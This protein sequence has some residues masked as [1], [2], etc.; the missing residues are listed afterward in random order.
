MENGQPVRVQVATDPI[1]Q[2]GW[3]AVRSTVAV[4]TGSKVEP[5]DTL[6]LTNTIF[7]RNFSVPRTAPR[8]FPERNF[9]V[10]CSVGCAITSRHLSG[11]A[12]PGL[13]VSACRP[14]AGL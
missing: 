8:D 3:E 2:Q 5:R 6:A 1:G 12:T 9:T 10:C 4:S 11:L 7:G 14:P 13:R